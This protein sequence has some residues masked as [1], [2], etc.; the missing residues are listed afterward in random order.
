[1]HREGKR[2]L[3]FV[4]TLSC[5]GA[6]RVAILLSHGLSRLGHTPRL[7]TAKKIGEFVPFLQQGIDFVDLDCG[8]PIRGMSKLAG[9]INV[10]NADAVIAFGMHT[11]IAAAISKKIHGWRGQLLIRNENNLELDWRQGNRLNRILG[12]ILS[13][14]SARQAKIIAVS[15]ALR[16]PTARYLGLNPAMVATIQNPVFESFPPPSSLLHSKDL[17]PW[18][19]EEGDPT[20]VAVGRLE[21]QKGFDNLISAFHLVRSTVSARLIIFGDGS[22]RRELQSQIEALGLE[23]CVALPGFTSKPMAQMKAARAFV[24]SSRFEG[25][26]LVLVEALASGTSVISTDC[27]YGPS[28]LLEGGRYGSLVPPNDPE[29]LAASLIR[30]ALAEARPILAPPED[31]FSPFLAEEASRRHIELMHQSR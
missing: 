31:W 24:L 1:M 3:L 11:G 23:D 16:L 13:R 8:K 20:F 30:V 4:P 10:F 12:P 2:V 19:R 26:G 27:D 6:E 21:W 5:G 14:W 25:F 18:L 17:H 15:E 29:E 9:Q 22:L 7:V 28:E